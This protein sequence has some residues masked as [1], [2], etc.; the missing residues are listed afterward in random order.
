MGYKHNFGSNT[1]EKIKPLI[2][3][4]ETAISKCELEKQKVLRQQIAEN[5]H[6]TYNKEIM[7]NKN[8]HAMQKQIKELNT[9]LVNNNIINTKADK[10]NSIVLIDNDDYNRKTLEFLAENNIT[11]LKKKSQ[12]IN[13]KRL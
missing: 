3:D 7:E 2:I 11:Q 6:K 12:L 10:G 1:K 5:I 8:T 9:K 4:A 13:F